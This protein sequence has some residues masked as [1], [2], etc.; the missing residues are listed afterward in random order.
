M[1]INALLTALA[2]AAQDRSEIPL[3]VEPKDPAAAKIVLL[4]GGFSKGR[5][6]HEY[7]AGSWL[8]QK[9][10]LQTPGVAPVLVADGWPRN[11]AV[12]DRARAVVF[13][14]DGGGKQPYLTP[15]RLARIDAL[16]AQGVGLVHLHQVIDYPEAHAKRAIAWLGGAYVPKASAR[17]HWDASFR[18][19]PAHP[20]TRGVTPFAENDGYLYK[21]VFAG[22]RTGLTPLLRT[23]PKGELSDLQDVVAW[24]YERPAGGRSFVFSGAHEQKAFGLEGKR[25]FV[26]NGILWAAGLEV[27]PSGAPVDLDPADL[28]RYLD[29]VPAGR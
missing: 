25:R 4:A 23:R 1:M 2:L 22:D 6:E 13:F 17:G 27:P 20:S 15:G 11:E 9:L 12:L 24:A 29:P 21:M 28:K 18:E 7:F 3:E 26:V 16:A 8:L 14:M 19:F 5:G 10:L